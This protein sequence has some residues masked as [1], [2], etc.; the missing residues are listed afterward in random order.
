[1]IGRI[2][3]RLKQLGLPL[4]PQRRSRRASAIRLDFIDS[5]FYRPSQGKSPASRVAARPGVLYVS[6]RGPSCNV[7][8]SEA[9]SG[10]IIRRMCS[11]AIKGIIST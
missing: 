11:T 6:Q 5:E 8:L 7:V 2:L 10:G 4:K 1:M 9:P 3:R